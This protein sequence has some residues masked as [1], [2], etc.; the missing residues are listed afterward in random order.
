MSLTHGVMCEQTYTL[1][2]FIPKLTDSSGTSSAERDSVTLTS[3][4]DEVIVT[5]L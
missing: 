2:V 3:S 5:E 4:T 1:T